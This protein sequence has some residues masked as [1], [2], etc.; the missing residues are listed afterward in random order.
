MSI[1]TEFLKNKN[2]I[3]KIR[4]SKVTDYAALKGTVY[5]LRDKLLEYIT[6]REHSEKKGNNSTDTMFKG[7]TPPTS[8]NRKRF[9]SGV[10]NSEKNF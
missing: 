9:N 10:G 7:N 2:I 1:F 6:A 4:R 3:F 5:A 8:E